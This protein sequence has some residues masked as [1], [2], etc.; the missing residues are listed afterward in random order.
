MRKKIMF[1]MCMAAL[2]VVFFSLG[3]VGANQVPPEVT[4]VAARV[5]NGA[6]LELGLRID[7]KND[8]FQS[9]GV[10]LEYDASA[11]KP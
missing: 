1:L 4:V 9:T 11:L 3:V 6:A 8:G 10:V 5:D 2:L 7:S